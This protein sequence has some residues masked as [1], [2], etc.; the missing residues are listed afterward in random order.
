MEKFSDDKKKEMVLA[1]LDKAK[2]I[3]ADMRVSITDIVEDINSDLNEQ[4][5]VKLSEFFQKWQE[6]ISILKLTGD[7]TK[8]NFQ[9]IVIGGKNANEVSEKL[10]SFLAEI[11]NAFKNE[12]L[13]ELRTILENDFLYGIDDLE[14]LVDILCE[15]IE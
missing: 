15:K 7:I 11:K 13:I 8:I 2:D 14:C 10:L 3:L 9:D 1:G 4:A 5:F 12:N 6:V